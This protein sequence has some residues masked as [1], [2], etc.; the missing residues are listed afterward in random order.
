[1]PGGTKRPQPLAQEPATPAQNGSCALRTSFA[2]ATA[3]VAALVAYLPSFAVPFQFDDYARIV[4]NPRLLK[5][6]VMSRLGS[7]GNA[8]FIPSATLMVNYWLGGT[9]A[10][11]GYHVGNFAVHLLASLGVFQL[12]LALCRTPRLRDSALAAHRLSFAMAA[13]LLFACHP[14]QTQAVTYIIQRSASMATMFY[15]WS[16]VLYVRGRNRTVDFAGRGA[17]R[18]FAACTAFAICAVLSKENAATLPLALLLTEWVFFDPRHAGRRVAAAVLGAAALGAIPI[19]W[20]LSA[21][22]GAGTARDPIPL[23]ARASRAI[24]RILSQDAAKGVSPIDYFLTQCTV[25]PR[26]LRL[27]F[28]PWGLNVDHDIPIARGLSAG[29]L[30]GFAFLAALLAMGIFARRRWPVL[31]FGIMWFFIAIGVESSFFPIRDAMMEHR[32]YLAMP[33]LALLIAAAWNRALCAR[34]WAAAGAGCF[35]AIALVALTYSRNQVWQTPLSLWTDALRKSPG[36]ARV[37]VNV[38]T[39]YHR[40]GQLDEAVRHYCTALGIDPTGDSAPLAQEN[41]EA[42]LSEQGKLGAV[43]EELMRDAQT[44]KHGPAGAMVLEFDVVKVACR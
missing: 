40:A 17:W 24:A 2:F 41:L 14:L 37:H 44:P 19:A 36:K 27:V 21:A 7:L 35:V 29:V 3:A 13:A 25:L 8:R 33:G 30:G 15:L 5:G 6:G 18:R 32:V 23:A 20:K 12:A 11:F 38:G 43:I 34:P 10:T 28:L 16:V 39:S 42:A 31:G 9:E 4:D 26:Y 22:L 1:M